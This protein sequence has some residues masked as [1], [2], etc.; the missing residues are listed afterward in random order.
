MIKSMTG[1][2]RG[3]FIYKSMTITAEVKAV[4]HRYCEVTVK[5]PRRFN[6]AE[7]PIKTVVKNFASRGKIEVNIQ[8]VD[9]GFDAGTI[10]LNMEAA[11]AYYEALNRLNQEVLDGNGAV[12]LSMLSGNPEVLK[13]VPPEDD[14]EELLAALCSAVKSA[15]ENFDRMR[16]TEGEKLI[17]D[18]LARGRFIEETTSAIEERAPEVKRAYFDKIKTRINDLLQGSVEIPE[19]RILVEAA[20]FADKADITEEITR[21]KSH[22]SQLKKISAAEGEPAGKKLDFLVQEMNR[23]S[24]TIGSKCND[25][26]ITEKV[27]QLKAEIEKIREQ[28]QNIE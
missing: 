4:N 2:G 25:I 21:L 22:C 10:H 15:C 14:E 16:Q 27:L 23:E 17:E 28:I 19:D 20:V 24:N 12:T 13:T 5:L 11:K 26:S 7:E 18:V 1:F 6:F 9:E 8:V 3:Q